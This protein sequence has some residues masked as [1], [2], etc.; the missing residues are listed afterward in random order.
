MILVLVGCN[1][2]SGEVAVEETTVRLLGLSI[3]FM[4]EE[5]DIIET[6]CGGGTRNG[7]KRGQDS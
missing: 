4:E 1:S 3:P 5:V 6:E 7:N 2:N